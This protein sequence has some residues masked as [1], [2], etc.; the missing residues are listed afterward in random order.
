MIITHT[1]YRLQDVLEFLHAQILVNMPP[2]AFA[3]LR[4]LAD[5]VSHGSCMVERVEYLRDSRM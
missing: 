3:S 4:G 1:Q 5:N 2:Q